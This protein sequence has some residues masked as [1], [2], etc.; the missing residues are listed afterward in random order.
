[1][2]ETDNKFQ[3]LGTFFANLVTIS[4]GA[5][6][7]WTSPMIPILQ[8]HKT[9]LRNGPL[10]D[11]QISWIGSLICVGAVL[12][13][14]IFGWICNKFGRKISIICLSFPQLVSWILIL[15]GTD[16][17]YLYFARF[18]AGLTAGG[19]FIAIPLYISEIADTRVRGSLGATVIFAENIGILLMYIAGSYMNYYVI[20]WIFALFAIGSIFGMMIV[21]DT[22]FFYAKTKRPKEAE[23]SLRY[24]RRI[25]I[26]DNDTEIIQ[27]E[28]S[29]LFS[30]KTENSSTKSNEDSSLKFSDFTTRHARKAILI[31]VFI[32]IYNQLSGVFAMLNYTATIFEKSGSSLSPNNS[33]IVGAGIQLLGNYC[34]TMTI[35]RLGRKFNM[36]LSAIGIALG[37]ASLATYSLFHSLKY[38]VEAFKWVPLASF[39]FIIF[40]SSIGISAILFVVISEILPEKIKDFTM[41]SLI[42]LVWGGAF[43]VIKLLPTLINE[44]KM[45]GAMYLLS[46]VSVVGTILLLI[47]QPETKEKSFEEIKRM[48]EK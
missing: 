6:C 39:S 27:E 30:F 47:L 34:A 12:G 3:Y 5:S 41:T 9:P 43:F 19:V 20:P 18:V 10:N 22:P 36:V 17:N 48:F 45:Y 32:V 44:L 11:D 2:S 24:Y 13:T 15:I 35:E 38:D 23:N 1:M 46:G 4:Y 33:A 16:V 14:L 40:I 21:A 42:F 7:G 26:S 25:K 28:L 37:Y 8:S 31:G 29:A